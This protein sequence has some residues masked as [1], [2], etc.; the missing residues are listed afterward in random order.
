MSDTTTPEAVLAR[1]SQIQADYS[2]NPRGETEAAILEEVAKDIVFLGS[3]SSSGLIQPI[4]GYKDD[5]G[6]IRLTEGFRR[7]TAIGHLIEEGREFNGTTEPDP[8][9]PV[10]ILPAPTGSEEDLVRIRLRQWASNTTG[11]RWSS[12]ATFRVI[13]ELIGLPRFQGH[14]GQTALAKEMGMTRQAFQPYIVVAQDEFYSNSILS[15]GTTDTVHRAYELLKAKKRVESAPAA[16]ALPAVQVPGDLPHVPAVPAYTAPVVPAVSQGEQDDIERRIPAPPAQVPVPS[17][18]PVPVADVQEPV[19]PPVLEMRAT[20]AFINDVKEVWEAAKNLIGDAT[21]VPACFP[22]QVLEVLLM[23]TAPNPVTRAAADVALIWADCNATAPEPEKVQEGETAQVPVSMP[24]TSDWNTAYPGIEWANFDLEGKPADY[25]DH[26]FSVIS[27][28]WGDGSATILYAVNR[29][30]LV[31]SYLNKT[32]AGHGG[33]YPTFKPDFKDARTSLMDSANMVFDNEYHPY[34]DE[35]Q[36]RRLFLKLTD[37]IDRLLSLNTTP[38]SDSAPVVA[39]EAA[40]NSSPQ[41]PGALADTIIEAFTGTQA[42]EAAKSWEARDLK[43]NKMTYRTKEGGGIKWPTSYIEAGTSSNSVI[44]RYVVLP[45][46]NVIAGTDISCKSPFAEHVCALTLDDPAF[47]PRTALLVQLEYVKE[48]GKDMF[49]SQSILDTIVLNLSEQIDALCP[50][51]SEPDPTPDPKPEGKEDKSA[52]WTVANADGFPAVY[53]TNDEGVVINPSSIEV[54]FKGAKGYRL[55]L[56]YAIFPDGQ[57]S[58]GY[59]ASNPRNI[60]GS[61]PLRFTRE[62][63]RPALLDALDAFKAKAYWGE[64]VAEEALFNAVLARI[65]EL[66]PAAESPASDP[67]PMDAPLPLDVEEWARFDLQGLPTGYYTTASREG[68]VANPS[69]INASL[70]GQ[71]H[72][73]VT[74]ALLP[75]GTAIGGHFIE[76]MGEA[77]LHKPVR[78][79]DPALPVREALLKELDALLHSAIDMPS[80]DKE[81]ACAVILTHIERVAPEVE[82]SAEPTQ[83]QQPSTVESPTT[84]EPA[85][86]ESRDA[87]PATALMFHDRYQGLTLRVL[88]YAKDDGLHLGGY[89][90]V[91]DFPK[92]S[93]NDTDYVSSLHPLPADFSGTYG[94][95]TERDAAWRAFDN[96]QEAANEAL[97]NGELKCQRFVLDFV[98][99]AVRDKVTSILGAAD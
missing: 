3:L 17:S 42:G 31:T 57:V 53:T 79:N 39:E 15:E 83:G 55:A 11:K 73:A 30:G 8:L 50:P 37:E 71:W 23:R 68:E 35:T 44:L 41:T 61:T 85:Q 47:E 16:P 45:D 87:F 99:G 97:A 94:F 1:F 76:H 48:K 24:K 7:Y 32:R 52:T 51:S 6:R 14:G 27:A 96:M 12:K 13:K 66:C 22:L 36:A 20:P 33:S 59:S 91:Y 82:S 18:S 64:P 43:G 28:I 4:E 10:I 78:Y 60:G 90:I 84:P 2:E 86:E 34:K 29:E 93:G 26:D 56:R 67:I 80:H 25:G 69:A 9:V 74:Y 21:H 89:D 5:K 75:D 70:N 63:L 40:P 49:P 62:N 98:L 88:T 38:I 65:D 54:N 95:E 58:A 81:D 46:G 72:V 92:N 19:R 77:L